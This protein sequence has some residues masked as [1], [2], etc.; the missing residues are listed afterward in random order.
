[1]T[2]VLVDTLFLRMGEL[3]SRGALKLIYPRTAKGA[4]VRPALSPAEVDAR[5]A[6]LEKKYQVKLTRRGFAP[7][8]TKRG[9]EIMQIQTQVVMA[10]L[11]GHHSSMKMVL[12]WLG[13]GEIS[14]EVPKVLRWDEE[15]EFLKALSNIRTAQLVTASRPLRTFKA[16][17]KAPQEQTFVQPRR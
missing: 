11:D 14:A 1:M 12:N 10:A 2:G 8:P 6:A 5:I 13:F 9:L 7:A 3:G 15:I 4:C 17:R 16:L